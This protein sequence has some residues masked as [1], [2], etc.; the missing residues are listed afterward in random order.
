MKRCWIKYS[1]LVDQNSRFLS[2]ALLVPLPLPERLER[3]G[4]SWLLKLRW[5]GAQRGQMKG[6]LSWLIRWACRAG[7]RYLCSALAALVGPVENIFSSPYTISV[8]LSPSPSK[9][10]RQPCWVACLLVCVSCLSYGSPSGPVFLPQFSIDLLSSSMVSVELS[11]A[12]I[13]RPWFSCCF[14]VTYS[15]ML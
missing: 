12:P 3:G 4:P 6:F 11:C 13:F 10:G 15:Y 14:F 5:M 9:L 8:T 1:S 7:T 2:I